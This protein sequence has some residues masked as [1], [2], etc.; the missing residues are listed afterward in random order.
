MLGKIIGRRYQVVQ[1]LGSSSYCQTYLARTLDRNQPAQCVIKHLLSTDKITDLSYRW[2]R[3]FSREIA[4]LEKLQSYSQVPQ[5]LDYF[6]E[7]R[8]F[9]L[10]Q[11]YIVGQPLSQLMP[12]VRVKWS[13]QQVIEL[14][15][16]ILSILEIVHSQ[17]LIH[18][19]LKP[20][21]LIRRASDGKLV[22][23]DFGS[24]KQAWTQ[25]VTSLGQTQANYAIGL[26][27]TIA[28]GTSGYMPSEQSHGRPRPNSDIYAL[29]MIA[30][31]ALTGMQ[32][33]QLLENA[34]T[35]EMIWQ[36]LVTIAPEL[37]AILN[38][39]VRYHF[40]ERYQSTTEALNDLA[41]LVADVP[42]I[43]PAPAQATA[44]AM[45]LVP[46]PA[47]K[48]IEAVKLER[49]RITSR[50]GTA[51]GVA[52]AF[53]LLLGSY[54]ALRPTTNISPTTARS[55]IM[56]AAHITEHSTS[57]Q[58]SV[59]R[60][61]TGHTNAVWAVAIARDGRTLVSGSGDKTIKFWDLSSGELL[62]TLTGNS[63][64]VLSL[65]LS[66][67]GQMLTSASY[68]AQPAV[69]VWDL[70]TQE[71]Q[72]TI[73]NVSKVWSVA[74]SPD[75]QTLVSSNADASIKIWDLPTRMLRRTL[76]GHADTVWS[77]A[78]SPDGKT[79]VSGSK[80]RT[81]K[82]WDLRT[83]ALRRTLLGHTDRVRSVA[84]SPDGQTLVSSSWDKTI[85]IWQ[86]QTGQRLRILTG[87]SDYINS[88][89]ISPD[90]QMIAS[91]S[92]DRQIKLWQ[93][94]TG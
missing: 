18:R 7:D 59:T 8:Q 76:I 3:L 32:P 89:A 73:G 62:R 26:P 29:G 77:V 90:S 52:S 38:K 35:G 6:E 80:D 82:I 60:T 69:K 20:N 47:D 66:Q 46:K 68:S 74:I 2:Q 22:L 48:M 37:T 67:D 4:A 81:I 93:L 10:V 72:Q 57:A 91:G 15:Y 44:T 24:V 17:G 30:I 36:H 23:I 27:A 9:Y 78:I 85:G 39:M 75:R 43:N 64:E 56:E 92:D 58:T 25:V 71:L 54:Y 28:V 33:T 65:A 55:Q 11:E 14:L 87:H 88:V 83:G 19:D 61:L 1:I 21:N 40:L 45:S 51:L 50:L 34:E 5:L 31:Q 94:N 63:A 16:E 84:I 86:L 13:Q 41:P 49:K 79:L 12:P 42:E 53:A 70:P